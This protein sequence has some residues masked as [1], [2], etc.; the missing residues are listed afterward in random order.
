MIGIVG[1]VSS[2]DGEDQELQNGQTARVSGMLAGVNSVS[3]Q[4]RPETRKIL[5]YVGLSHHPH[6]TLLD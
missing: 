6:Q 1:I 5:E 2:L 3:E 4:E